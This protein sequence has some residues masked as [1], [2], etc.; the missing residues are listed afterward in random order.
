M[1]ITKLERKWS[2]ISFKILGTVIR[3]SIL[4]FLIVLTREAVPVFGVKYMVLP[5]RIGRNIPVI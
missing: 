1:V 5:I 3:V 2:F 4:F